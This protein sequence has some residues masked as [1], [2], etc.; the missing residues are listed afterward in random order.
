MHRPQE[1]R[2]VLGKPAA[3]TGPGMGVFTELAGGLS[4]KP[5]SSP[6][7]WCAA[8]VRVDAVSW[9]PLSC[10]ASLR[11]SCGDRRASPCASRWSHW[12]PDPGELQ[13]AEASADPAPPPVLKVNAMGSS[14]IT[15][16][17]SARHSPSA[18]PSGPRPADTGSLNPSTPCLVTA[19]P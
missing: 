7:L 16:S 13:G 14:A 18:C 10:S 11:L 17:S 4:R 8:F 19:F 3:H 1:T 2:H 6:P 15:A 9:V 5:R 12:G